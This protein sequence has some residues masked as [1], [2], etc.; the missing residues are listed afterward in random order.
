MGSVLA[1]HNIKLYN[2]ADR[3]FALTETEKGALC[4][5]GVDEAKILVTEAGVTPSRLLG[6]QRERFRNRYS[7]PANAAVVT[8]LSMKA[9][10]KGVM[11]TVRAMERVWERN[12]KARLVLAGG[13]T[14][15]FNRF[16]DQ[17][18]PEARGRCVSL[19]YITEEEKKDLLAATDI[20]VMPSR[21][22][23][24]GIVFLEG[25]VYGIPVIGASAGGVPEVIEDGVDGFLVPFGAEELL[26]RKVTL[27]LAQPRLAH[28]MGEAG[29]RKV[30][31]R[32]T[33]DSL[34]PPVREAYESLG[35]SADVKR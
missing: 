27:L 24:F 35:Q 20:L 1:S 29:R 2:S 9:Y 23:S 32:L 13:A 3:V 26:A 14:T 25:W 18:G 12:E 10:D 6:G 11:H 34:Y 28:E 21:A 33:W 5:A 4:R 22:D 17:L 7:I 30:L 19:D 15:T 8:Q 31:N 16:Y